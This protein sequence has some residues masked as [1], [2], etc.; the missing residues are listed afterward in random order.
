MNIPVDKKLVIL[1]C[2]QTAHEV[3]R[4]YCIGTCDR[5]Q[6]VWD[7]APEWQQDSAINGVKFI[8]GNPDAGVEAA[9]NAWLKEKSETGWVY[10]PTKDPIAKVHPC[11]L[12]YG[13]L[14]VHEQMKDT[15]FR[16]TVIGIASANGWDYRAAMIGVEP[17]PG[18]WV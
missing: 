6:V 8:L 2:A 1:D 5:S 14:P 3:N 4:M 11:I 12:P 17:K 13:E 7:L 10:G 15:L 16:A 18:L 9:H